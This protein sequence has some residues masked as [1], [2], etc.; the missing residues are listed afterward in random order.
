MTTSSFLNY[1]IILTLALSVLTGFALLALSPVFSKHPQMLLVLPMAG[2][3]FLMLVVN[4]RWTFI[5]VF[6]T[7]PLL[8]IFLNLTKVSLGGQEIG[9]GA[10]LNL[11]IIVLAVFLFFYEGG[12][13]R[14]NPAV[15]GWAIFLVVML[16]AV[17][18]SPYFGRAIRLYANYLSFFSM[19]LVPF[20]VIKS[21]EDYMFWLKAFAWSFVLPVFYA[22]F[23][24]LNGGQFYPDAGIRIKGSF[25]HP[26]VLAFYLC[27]G[28]TYYF[29]LLNGRL[30]QVNRNIRAAMVAVVVNMLALLLATKSRNAWI[31]CFFSFFIYG[32]LR[33]RKTLLMLFMM[34]P[35]LLFV[36]SVQDRVGTLF[37]TNS[38]IDYK[39]VNSFEWRLNMWKSSLPF[40][41]RKPLQG[42][43]LTSFKELSPQFS[44]ERASMGAHNV[45]IEV[46]FE[47]GLI[48]LAA[49][50]FLFL[51]PLLFFWNSMRRAVNRVT[52]KLWAIV[53][54]YILSY[55]IICFADNL[56]YYLVFNWYVW[57]FI[58]LMM[59]AKKYVE[60]AGLEKQT[61]SKRDDNPYTSR[62]C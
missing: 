10:I 14:R 45:Y 46:L 56:S 29:Y 8:D 60:P 2:A 26:N 43:G 28:I 19:F 40:V 34:M 20:L 47:A 5:L 13:P 36:P 21:R 6:L 48:G 4:P 35:L 24:L 51:Q 38:S 50:I 39:G 31:A 7:R 33:D 54:G 53:V 15:K 42:Y 61:T 18:Y 62:K 9:I 58:G 23:D 30:L 27:L 32:L 16:F 44:E 22:N 3:F 49:Y 17:I 11:V 25:S 1:R 52:A 41:A 59:V 12:F 37:N 57:F 55:M